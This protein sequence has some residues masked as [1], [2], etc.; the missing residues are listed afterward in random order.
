M[1]RSSLRMRLPPISG[2]RAQNCP[3]LVPNGNSYHGVCLRKAAYS[4]ATARANSS[5]GVRCGPLIHAVSRPMVS[6]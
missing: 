4:S 5:S 6:S 2:V 3:S 1:R